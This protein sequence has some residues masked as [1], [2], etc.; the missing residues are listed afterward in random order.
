MSHCLDQCWS[1]LPRDIC[2]T[3]PQCVK[4]DATKLKSYLPFNDKKKKTPYFVTQIII[5]LWQFKLQCPKTSHTAVSCPKFQNDWTIETGVLPTNE[6]SLVLCLRLD[7]P[8]ISRIV[9][10]HCLRHMVYY[11]R[12]YQL[13]ILPVISQTMVFYFFQVIW[14]ILA[15]HMPLQTNNESILSW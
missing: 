9:P 15:V 4:C 7:F 14:N 1:S 11:D 6:T 3:E 13:S 12:G 10:P 2:A 5:I 8:E